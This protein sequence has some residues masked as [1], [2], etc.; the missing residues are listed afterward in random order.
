MS[1]RANMIFFMFSGSVKPFVEEC[2]SP[3]APMKPQFMTKMMSAFSFK[4]GANCP[5]WV[6]TTSR[7]AS[8]SP[9]RLQ[10]DQR[11]ITFMPAARMASKSARTEARYSSVNGLSRHS[12]TW[13]MRQMMDSPF[14]RRPA[15]TF[16]SSGSRGFDN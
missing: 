1:S 3:Q 12:R 9:I 11:G 10:Y 15:S 2:I 13:N 16:A 6:M 7:G 5:M 8:S 14:A 4:M